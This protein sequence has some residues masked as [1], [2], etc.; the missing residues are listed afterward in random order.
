M[1]LFESEQKFEAIFIKYNLKN[2]FN[3]DFQ[4]DDRASWRW[5]LKYTQE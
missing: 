4:I 2:M 1:S 5:S 3:W